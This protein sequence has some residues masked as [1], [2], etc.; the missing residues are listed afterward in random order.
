MLSREFVN[1]LPP[2]NYYRESLFQQISL[3]LVDKDGVK[4]TIFLKFYKEEGA[5]KDRGEGGK[6]IPKIVFHLSLL[7]TVFKATIL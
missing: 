7:I 4:L 3:Q 1:K 6:K 2:L 5:G